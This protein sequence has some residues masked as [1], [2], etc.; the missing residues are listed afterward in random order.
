M[1]EPQPEEKQEEKQQPPKPS[2]ETERKAS[3]KFIQG[4]AQ[5]Q[6]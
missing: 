2:F 4:S 6:I 1:S 3:R 5:T